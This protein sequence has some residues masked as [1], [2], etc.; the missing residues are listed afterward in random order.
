MRRT[1]IEYDFCMRAAQESCMCWTH[2][3]KIQNFVTGPLRFSTF[4]CAVLDCSDLF[5]VLSCLCVHFWLLFVAGPLRSFICR[6]L[7]LFVTGLLHSFECFSSFFVVTGLLF[8]FS[9]TFRHCRV[10]TFCKPQAIWYA[11]QQ[12]SIHP[13][14]GVFQELMRNQ[15]HRLV[16]W[17]PRIPPNTFPPNL[18]LLTSQWLTVRCTGSSAVSRGQQA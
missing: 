1:C 2:I 5:D 13:L 3:Q 9:G 7:S 12:S 4:R 6:Y 10:C 17:P 15:V 11:R 16:S 14:P 18:V 8:S